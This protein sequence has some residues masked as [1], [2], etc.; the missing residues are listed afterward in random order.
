MCNK[1]YGPVTS[2]DLLLNSIHT[3]DMVTKTIVIGCNAV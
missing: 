2:C 3:L 1:I